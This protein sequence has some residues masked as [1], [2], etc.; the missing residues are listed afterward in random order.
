MCLMPRQSPYLS[1]YRAHIIRGPRVSHFNISALSLSHLF[2]RTTLP[3]PCAVPLPLPVR[4]PSLPRARRTPLTRVQQIWRGRDPARAAAGREA[5]AM[6]LGPPTPEHL[7]HRG[8]GAPSFPSPPLSVD[9][10]APLPH[11]RAR[12]SVV[13]P[14]PTL[15]RWIRHGEVTSPSPEG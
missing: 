3:L 13:V 8:S 10:A 14:C 1:F 15:E 12:S 11:Y 4:Q 7:H 2:P 6:D 5:T 9:P